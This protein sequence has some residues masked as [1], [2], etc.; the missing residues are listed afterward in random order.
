MEVGVPRSAAAWASESARTFVIIQVG[1]ERDRSQ[2]S[3]EGEAEEHGAWPHRIG[4]LFEA[5]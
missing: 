5:S 2:E 4:V 3:H 1:L